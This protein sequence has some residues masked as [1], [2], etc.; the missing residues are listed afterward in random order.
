MARY[1]PFRVIL[2]TTNR[3][4][5]LRWTRLGFLCKKA[6]QLNY[7]VKITSPNLNLQNDE[8]LC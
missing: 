2:C 7:T 4:P 5:F 3:L 6:G 1:D 8:T